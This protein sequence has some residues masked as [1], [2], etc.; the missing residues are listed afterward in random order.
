MRILIEFWLWLNDQLGPDFQKLSPMRSAKEVELNEG[1]TV[2]ELLDRLANEYPLI[3]EK[4]FDPQ[5]KKL[6]PNLSV[7]VTQDER[8]VSP[9]NLDQDLLQDAYKITIL[10]IY[11]GG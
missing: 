1:I 6:R 11:V 4:I 5:A 10:P 8:V 2:G 3:G 9:F 7:I